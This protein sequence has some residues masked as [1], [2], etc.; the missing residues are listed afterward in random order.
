MRGASRETRDTATLLLLAFASATTDILAYLA[1]SA[2]TSAMTGNT[3]LLGVALGQGRAAATSSALA[4]LLAFIVGVVVAT[5]LG[6]LRWPGALRAALGL[7]VLC[8]ALF[9]LVWIGSGHGPAASY[10]LIV[11]SALGMGAQ[12]VAARRIDLPGIPTVVFT[13]TLTSICIAA[14]EA[15]L[16]KRPLS[17]DTIRQM[18][19]FVIYLAGA[20]LA[21]VLGARE[22]GTVIFL[23]LIAVLA[24]FALQAGTR[25]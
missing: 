19:A 10:K 5:L 25:H 22:L 2:F 15:V 7:E 14:T 12:I 17:A 16:R 21:G 13:S 1:L 24:A 23:P 11:L 6:H 8:L 4:A 3:A 18:A 9:V 20:A